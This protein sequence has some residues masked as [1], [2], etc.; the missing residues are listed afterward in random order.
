MLFSLFGVSLPSALHWDA[1]AST[2][3]PSL[4]GWTLMVGMSLKWGEQQW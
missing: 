3:L 1:W 2:L 4:Q